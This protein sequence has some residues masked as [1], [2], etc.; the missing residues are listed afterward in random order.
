M[1]VLSGI[2]P[3]RFVAR[4][5]VELTAPALVGDGQ[6]GMMQDDVFL[7]DV[8]GL[9]MLAGTG[10]AG[11]L[12][13]A[14]PGIGRLEA[15][16]VRD[17][18]FGHVTQVGDGTEAQG[19]RLIVSDGYFHGQDDRPVT[20]DVSAWL[21]Q[22]DV[23]ICGLNGVTRDHVRIGPRGTADGAGKFDA[24]Y[25]PAG[26]RFTFELSL[27]WGAPAEDAARDAALGQK[28][29]DALIASLASPALRFGQKTR[30]GFGT[31]RLVRV[32]QT[33]FWLAAEPTWHDLERPGFAAKDLDDYLALP[34]DLAKD[35]SAILVRSEL[36]QP[37][38][39]EL[40]TITL[41][42][43]MPQD[44]WLFGG[45]TPQDRE[46]IAPVSEPVITWQQTGAVRQACALATG[47]GIKGAL[48]HRTLWHLNRLSGNWLGRPES[49][50][51]TKAGF[52][53]LFGDVKDDTAGTGHAGRLF[54]QDIYLME[55]PP[56]DQPFTHNVIDRFTSGV[57]AGLLFQERTKTG[58]DFGAPVILIDTA[59]RD[60][61]PT[62]KVRT[63]L[64]AALL[65][66]A[67]GWLPLGGG[68]GRGHGG[69]TASGI[70][71]DDRARSWF[72]AEDGSGVTE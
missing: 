62:P 23:L 55:T 17:I 35:A 27:G 20:Q 67:R 12:S 1:S 3:I 41:Q 9:P 21:P 64:R 2:D 43:L 48:A 8:H 40:G 39:A 65:D 69:F 13:H 49:E 58:G 71:L 38:M 31:F 10:I 51:D 52:T 32:E 66:L 60:N 37:S 70:G 63:A 28:V 45:G 14:V 22:E 44:T 33:T 15:D 11:L 24:L 36:P 6:F 5:T 72:A 47:T 68:S 42:G 46:D 30:S 16:T 59:P 34:A 4:V 19:S 26:S 18:V 25:A 56:Q 53:S 54:F 57:R 50:E 29:W 61:E 7:R